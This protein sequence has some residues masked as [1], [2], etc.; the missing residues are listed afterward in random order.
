[1]FL[2]DEP[3][4]N[5]DAALRGQ[6]RVE[7]RQLQKRLDTT[8]VFVTH[9]QVEA[10]TLADRILLMNQGRVEQIGAPMELYRAPRTTYVASFI[11]APSMNLVDGRLDEAGS[12]FTGAGLALTLPEPHPAL[13]GRAVTLGIRPEDLHPAEPGRPGAVS[14]PVVLVERLGADQVVFSRLEGHGDFLVRLPGGA[15]VEEGATL[16]VAPDPAGIHLFYPESGLRLE[17]PAARAAA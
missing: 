6:M 5:L 4:S 13:G 11:G 14:L 7:I 15:P 17:L 12:H 16:T 10:M 3:L 2:F 1:V 9:D 8:G